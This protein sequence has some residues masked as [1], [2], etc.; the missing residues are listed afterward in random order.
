VALALAAAAS[1]VLA[2]S[3]KFMTAKIDN[4]THPV[5]YWYKYKLK[6]QIQT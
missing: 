6:Q 4:Q 1:S 2:M 3:F 5:S